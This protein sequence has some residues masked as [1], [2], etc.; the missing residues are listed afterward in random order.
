MN[1]YTCWVVRL[2]TKKDFLTLNINAELIT[3][4]RAFCP[5]MPP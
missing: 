4:A 3:N 5:R 1:T 2:D